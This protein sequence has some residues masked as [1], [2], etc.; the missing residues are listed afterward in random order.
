MLRKL[1]A[2]IAIAGSVTGTLGASAAYGLGLGDIRLNSALNQPLD[3][4]I[5]LVQVRELTQGE[6]LPS[7]ATREDFERAG[8]ERPYFLSELRFRTIK[9]ED[10]TAYVRVTSRKPVVEPYLNFLMEVHWPD[11]RL[12]REY[13]L[14]LDPP[15]FSNEVVAASSTPKAINVP[16]PA[17]A[18]PPAPVKPFKR[19]VVTAPV[20]RNSAPTSPNRGRSSETYRVKQG[21]TLWEVA[22][23]TRPGRDVTPVRMMAA[24]QSE[25]P[26]AFINGNINLLKQGSLLSIPDR[27][28][29]DAL[30]GVAANRT[31]AEQNRQWQQ[32]SGR[33]QVDA[34][35]K[36]EVV[37]T[38]RGTIEQDRLNIV[39]TG[40]QNSA[41][42][43]SDQGGGSHAAGTRALESAISVNQEQ[44][45]TLSRENTDLKGRLR[46]LEEQIQS[47]ETLVVLKSDELTAAQLLDQQVQAAQQQA[48]VQPEPEEEIDYNYYEVEELDTS[49]SE[50]TASAGGASPA[51]SQ[52]DP[53]ESAFGGAPAAEPDLMSPEG[54]MNFA[55]KNQV[56]LVAGGGS[57][58]LILAIVALL[59]RRRRQQAEEDEEDVIDESSSDD[60]EDL[61]EVEDLFAPQESEGNE[62]SAK[63]SD[64]TSDLDI[65]KELFDEPATDQ[66]QSADPLGEAD[67]Y[68]AYGRL[69]Q[70][71]ELL[72][73]AISESPERADLRIKLMEVMADSQNVQG[74]LAQ[75]KALE[76]LGSSEGLNRASELRTRFP[77]GAFDSTDSELE[78][79][80][81]IAES[82]AAEEPIQ[83]QKTEEV[84]SA[85]DFDLDL[86]GE[87]FDTGL[88]FDLDDFDGATDAEQKPESVGNNESEQVS[89]L[90]AEVEATPEEGADESGLEDFD[91]DFESLESDEIQ[92]VAEKQEELP[93]L[94][95]LELDAG[96]DFEVSEPEAVE[97]PATAESEP[98]FEIDDELSIDGITLEETSVDEA[99]VT[100]A[101]PAE[102]LDFD[103]ELEQLDAELADLSA[104]FDLDDAAVKEGMAPETISGAPEQ[105]SQ[106][107]ALTVEQEN[108]TAAV[109]VA[110]ETEAKEEPAV[111]QTTADAVSEQLDA[112]LAGITDSDAAGDLGQMEDEFSFLD[113]TDE[114][115]TKLDLA[116]AYMEMGDEEGAKDILDEVVREGSDVQQQEAKGLIEKIS[117]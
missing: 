77:A 73:T 106:P 21:D 85:D 114:T 65:D 86:G 91:L 17:P 24:L 94:Q 96:L 20:S 62:E 66:A 31:V 93:E 81:T 47:L 10:G 78:P 25:N 52:V 40:V 4:E 6:V 61:P 80:Q 117:G 12:L 13:T 28:A 51:S 59:A 53:I 5:E 30:D 67:I 27:A 50:N 108:E 98:A 46:E 15:S 56:Y 58:V 88:E 29:I 115:A 9:R 82:V 22:L 92:E 72:S 103:T 64:V 76:N 1:A 35:R 44:L 49:A 11:G 116:R 32:S 84:A 75:E 7:M 3:A 36:T 23:R 112:A 89:E 71:T 42:D 37:E 87:E 55:M 39:T 99:E 70:A 68:I 34:T 18:P 54:L 48:T 16:K 19:P 74:F 95:D 83:A 69:E 79:A 60:L 63:E 100:A 33:V 38:A 101:Q 107:D 14:L 90:V 110:S 111:N 26:S 113:D 104:D 102:N 97:T 105:A 2:A 43:A 45:D 41:K 8:V 57:L 109:A